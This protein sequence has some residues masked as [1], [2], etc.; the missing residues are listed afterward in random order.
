MGK[1][2]GGT[3]SWNISVL[4][5]GMCGTQERVV[6]YVSAT[7]P[8]VSEPDG[9]GR[10]EVERFGTSR[11]VKLLLRWVEVN[12]SEVPAV[13]RI[14]AVTTAPEF[15]GL[16]HHQVKNGQNNFQQNQRGYDPHG[17]NVVQLTPGAFDVLLKRNPDRSRM[18]CFCCWIMSA[19]HTMANVAKIKSVSAMYSVVFELPA[20]FSP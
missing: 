10:I 5:V 19:C 15:C 6:G 8:R 11:N 3:G 16:S 20:I 12:L 7:G 18:T 9:Q 1:S 14:S 4:R 17:Q 2:D 13:T